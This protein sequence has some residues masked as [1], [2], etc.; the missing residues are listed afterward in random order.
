MPDSIVP[1]RPAVIVQAAELEHIKLAPHTTIH[2]VQLVKPERIQVREQALAR[3]VRTNLV[4]RRVAAAAERKRVVLRVMHK[5]ERGRQELG[6]LVPRAN[7][8]PVSIVPMR[9]A[10]VAQA[11][12]QIHIKPA[13]R[14]TTR[15]VM[16]V[17]GAVRL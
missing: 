3:P 5:Q 4:P 9:P 6:L 1:M 15:L 2:P 17:H 16:R 13:P 7:A 8:V 10:A 11:V 14:T 12:Q